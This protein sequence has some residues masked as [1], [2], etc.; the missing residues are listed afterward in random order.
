M[1][2]PE[3]VDGYLQ[4][5]DEATTAA[6][7]R[8][9]RCEG[10]SCGFSSGANVAAALDLLDG[11]CRG[12]T[13]VTILHDSGLKY[14]SAPISGPDFRKV[15][16]TRFKGRGEPLSKERLLPSSSSRT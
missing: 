16:H 1:M 11:P 14:L 10:L 4:V 7:R 15:Y 12:G 5:C 2:R 9:A 13:V 6:A 8:L 3:H